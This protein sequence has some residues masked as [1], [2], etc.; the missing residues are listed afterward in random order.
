MRERRECGLAEFGRVAFLVTVKQ[1]SSASA[2]ANAAGI[3]TKSVLLLDGAARV[4]RAAQEQAQCNGWPV[5]IAVVDD[6]GHPLGLIRLDRAAPMTAMIALAKARAAAISRCETIFFES[7][8]NS[9]RTAFLAVPGAEGMLEGGVPIIVD[10]HVIGAVG[11]SG[12]ES[13][14]DA[15]IASAG[16]SALQ[17]AV[18]GA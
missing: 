15:Q 3:S 1:H 6:G 17:R 12:V 18:V 16:I 7:M 10:G 11:V 13:D 2:A 4:L 9:G 8:I 5:S 14:K